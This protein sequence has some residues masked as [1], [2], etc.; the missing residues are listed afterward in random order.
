ME[1]ILDK[2][3]DEIKRYKSKIIA[4][5]MEFAKTDLLLFWD[6]KPDLYLQQEKEWG[7]ILTWVEQE[8]NIK[9][10]KSCNLEVPN[11]ME[12]QNLLKMVLVNMPDKELACYYAAALNMKSVLLALALIKG[13][14]DA[15][16]ASRLSYLDELWQNNL[17][18][19]DEEALARRA[20]RG[21]ELKKIEGY[22]LR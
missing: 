13:R 4:E 11:N 12:F 9:L 17:W 21:N 18:G 14:V 6:D 2:A 5:L 8:L 22:L 19:I 7:P 16:N 3:V 1:N 10:N 20:D 15:E